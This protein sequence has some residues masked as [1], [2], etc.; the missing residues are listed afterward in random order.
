M[1]AEQSIREI[2]EADRLPGTPWDALEIHVDRGAVLLLKE[3]DLIDAGEAFAKDDTA[4]VRN[5]LEQGLLRRPE[6]ED[7]ARFRDEKP[8][9]EALIVQPWVLVRTERHD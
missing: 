3:I 6:P 4:Q 5:W 8:T 9:F 1:E 2:L 7:V